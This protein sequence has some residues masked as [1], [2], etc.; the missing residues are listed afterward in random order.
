[1]DTHMPGQKQPVAVPTTGCLP[2]TSSLSHTWKLYGH[3]YE[4]VHTHTYTHNFRCC[5]GGGRACVLMAPV[6]CC[7]L[8]WPLAR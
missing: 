2:R 4:V 3:S 5:S 7:L 1:M 6:A 8:W